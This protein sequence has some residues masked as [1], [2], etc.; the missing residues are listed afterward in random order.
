[1]VTGC[2]GQ[3]GKCAAAVYHQLITSVLRAE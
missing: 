3:N 1:M 2:A